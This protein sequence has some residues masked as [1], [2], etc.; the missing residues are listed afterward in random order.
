MQAEPPHRLGDLAWIK[1][2]ESQLNACPHPLRHEEAPAA[3]PSTVVDWTLE[4]RA[5]VNPFSFELPPIR[6]QS[7]I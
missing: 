5:Y 1:M 2:G 4:P 7:Q 3:M 6:D